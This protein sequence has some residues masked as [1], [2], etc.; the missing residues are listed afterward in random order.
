MSPTEE[1][2]VATS[3]LQDPREGKARSCFV[4]EKFEGEDGLAHDDHVRW[5]EKVYIS[6]NLPGLD[7]PVLFSIA[8]FLACSY[9]HS[10]FVYLALP[11]LGTH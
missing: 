3:N 8:S 1:I 2:E 4:F 6:I 10:F 9:I 7:K 11:V 5:G